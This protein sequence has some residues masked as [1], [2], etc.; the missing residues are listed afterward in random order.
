MADSYFDADYSV[1]EQNEK[2]APVVRTATTTSNDTDVKEL[3]EQVKDYG[4][5]KPRRVITRARIHD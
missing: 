2:V 1:D 5:G 4:T 3:D